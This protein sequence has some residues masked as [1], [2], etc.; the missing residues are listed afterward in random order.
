MTTTFSD[1]VFEVNE[2]VLVNQAGVDTLVGRKEPRLEPIEGRV[3]ENKSG[4][5]WPY[6]V[7]VPGHGVCLFT[8]DELDK[9]NE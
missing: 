4:L 3:V 5:P 7:E 8:V 6:H 2:R 1:K 9:I